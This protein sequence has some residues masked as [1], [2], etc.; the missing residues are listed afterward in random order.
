MT[1]INSEI[2]RLLK[3]HNINETEGLLVLCSIYF[4]LGI[5]G[6][7]N[8]VLHETMTQINMVKIV[9]RNYDDGSVVW[10]VPLFEGDNRDSAWK[11]VVDEYRPLF[12]AVSKERA[13]SP[14]GCV[15]RMKKFFAD[16]PEVRKED[17]IEAVKIYIRNTQNPKY[18]QSADYFIV[19]DKG[20]ATTSRLEQYIEIVKEAQK[21]SN[22]AKM[23]GR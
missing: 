12:M 8:A 2:K 6:Q 11:W 10:N 22:Q 15:K 7:L 5:E 17:V 13:G 20:A 1:S 3:Q 21:K 19:K 18:L 14:S 23:M 4:E 9:E 16:H